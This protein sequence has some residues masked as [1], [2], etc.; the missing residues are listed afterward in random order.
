M[1]DILQKTFFAIYSVITLPFRWV[2]GIV[3][4]IYSLFFLPQFYMHGMCETLFG[5][6]YGCDILNPDYV[7]TTI[8]FNSIKLIVVATIILRLWTLWNDYKK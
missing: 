7:F 3:Y 8:L 5:S 1:L 4:F 6:G 2:F